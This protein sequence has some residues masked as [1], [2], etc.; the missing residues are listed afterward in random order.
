M[1]SATVMQDFVPQKFAIYT[2]AK[3]IYPYQDKYFMRMYNKYYNNFKECKC[4][5]AADILCETDDYELFINT[6]CR[7]II[8]N[9]N[10][11][12]SV[13]DFQNGNVFYDNNLYAVV[14]WQKLDIN[15]SIYGVA[16]SG[17]FQINVGGEFYICQ[18][19]KGSIKIVEGENYYNLD[20]YQCVKDLFDNILFKKPN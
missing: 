3:Q 11:N 7:T 10:F 1:A 20:L 2:T 5:E 18:Q 14:N 13:F 8:V 15:F 17:L 6:V 12:Y 4:P 9:K 19:I 16:L